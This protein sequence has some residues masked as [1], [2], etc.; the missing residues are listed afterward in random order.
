MPAGRSTK[1]AKPGKQPAAKKANAPATPATKKTTN[2]AAGP[3]KVQSATSPVTL[4]TAKTA[5]APAIPAAKQAA[6]ASTSKVAMASFVTG[7]F[8]PIPANPN[9]SIP[10]NQATVMSASNSGK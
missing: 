8:N 10:N 7:I 9:T 1:A 5:K 6:N 3:D 2:F 4:T